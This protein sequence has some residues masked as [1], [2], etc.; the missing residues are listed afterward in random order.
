MKSGSAE[1]L[2]SL[3]ES[4]TK[5]PQHPDEAELE[6]I[7]FEGSEYHSVTLFCPEYTCACP[8]TG[9]P[10]F[11]TLYIQY[12][13]NKWLVESKALKLYLFSFRNYGHFHEVGVDRIAKTLFDL[14]E[15]K[16]MRVIGDFNKRGGIAIVPRAEY[17]DME[18]RNYVPE[19]EIKYGA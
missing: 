10:D 9:Q 14:L 3:G 13:P 15:P 7:P 12:I 8:K 5:Y 11:A 17:G 19:P 18:L 16:Y 6:K 2:K 1:H 4:Q